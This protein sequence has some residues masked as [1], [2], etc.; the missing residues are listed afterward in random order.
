MVETYFI[1]TIVTLDIRL[2]KERGS[3]DDRGRLMFT[4][5]PRYLKVTDNKIH[6]DR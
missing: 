4:L 3:K 2:R 1:N 5:V 6:I